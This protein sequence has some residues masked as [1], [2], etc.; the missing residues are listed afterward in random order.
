MQV[1]DHDVSVTAAGEAD[2]VVW[3]DGQSV[4]G[5]S[6]GRQ[7]SLDAWS[8]R[9][10]VPD[11]QRAGLAPD[12]QSPPIWKELAWPDVVVSILIERKSRLYLVQLGWRAPTTTLTLCRSHQ[13]VQLGHRTLA[14][15]LADVPYFDAAFPAG[16][17]V[18]CGGADGHRAHH[19]SM[20]E[21]VDLTG[22]TW[23]ARAEEGVRREGHRLHLTICAH[24]ER[25][26][27]EGEKV[28]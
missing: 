23:D 24:V 4:A 26:S 27:S 10:Q 5:R 20:T 25:I 12:Y 11:W 16:V 6:R 7:F 8:G 15:W 17:D 3:T 2:L 22:V 18:T 1:P 13:T 21:R 14:A 9:G 19:L 28:V